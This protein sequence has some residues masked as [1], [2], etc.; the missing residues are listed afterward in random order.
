LDARAFTDP[1]AALM[2]ARI[3]A[4]NLL[5]SDV[6]MPGLDGYALSSGVTEDCPQCKVLLF[7][8]NPSVREDFARSAAEKKLEILF[9]PVLPEDLL[10]AIRNK[11]EA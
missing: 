11:L 3:E 1:F 4:P 9:K 10:Q 6:I 5:L 2:A 7:S 8:G